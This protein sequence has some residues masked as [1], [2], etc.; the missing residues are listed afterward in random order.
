MKKRMFTAC[1]MAMIFLLS[2]ALWSQE[3]VD[4]DMVSKIRHEGIKH[5]QVMWLVG[6]LS[7]VIGP[8]PTGSPS[9]MRT[10][11]SAGRRTI[12]RHTS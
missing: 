8:R 6:Y 10:S 4:W 3:P 9:L 12:F 1:V 11:A 2:G 7:D 5:S